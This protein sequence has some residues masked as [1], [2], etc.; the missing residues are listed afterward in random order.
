MCLLLHYADQWSYFTKHVRTFLS[1][2]NMVISLVIV[3]ALSYLP[4]MDQNG[5]L[6]RVNIRVTPWN[7]QPTEDRSWWTDPFDGISH[8]AI[9]G[10]LFPALMFYLLFFID[11]N[12]S[13]I[14][15]QLPKYNL[16]KPPAYHWDFFVLG[17]TFLPCG[18]LGLPPG[19]G[20]I[21]QAPLHTRALC[22]KR[23]EE[24][25]G[26]MREVY[27]SCTEQ[28]YSGFLQATLMFVALSLMTVISWIPV[29]SLF[30]VLLYLGIVALSGNAIW[31]RLLFNAMAPSK[32]PPVPCV[33][34]IHSWSTVRWYTAVQVACTA[35]IFGVSQFA[36]IG[37]SSI[38]FPLFVREYIA[39]IPTIVLSL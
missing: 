2:Y 36:S 23:L 10:A 13:G 37:T 20:L 17:V 19:N 35:I 27:T 26:V 18:F 14:L 31:E 7:W 38:C 28:R 4:G 32:R 15:S 33:A 30:G 12:V 5:A 34:K 25:D 6:E 29:G 22:T 21:P 11:H 1:A 39:T 8:G 9:F 24:I 16:K 3:T